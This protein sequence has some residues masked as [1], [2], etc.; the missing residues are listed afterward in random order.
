MLKVLKN[1]K[2]LIGITI[3]VVILSF[4]LMV[5]AGD[6]E[7]K[8]I[9]QEDGNLTCSYNLEDMYVVDYVYVYDKED[10]L[11]EVKIKTTIDTTKAIEEGGNSNTLNSD[12]KDNLN[13]LAVQVK[14]E[15]IQIKLKYT[16]NKG[17]LEYTVPVGLLSKFDMENYDKATKEEIILN[18]YRKGII[19]YTED[20]LKEIKK[21]NK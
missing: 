7:G 20:T 16:T 13:R 3:A 5:L 12:M 8:K 2:V 14:N 1:P 18:N 21:Q 6:K 11:K 17:V 15:G 19:C 4:V 10:V 9:E